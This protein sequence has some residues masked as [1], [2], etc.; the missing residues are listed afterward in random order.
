MSLT[1]YLHPLSSYCHKALIALY[2]NATPFEPHVVDLGSPAARAEF[3]KVW[4]F[5]KFPV[6]RDSTRTQTIPESTSI[7]EY[8]TRHYPGPLRLVPD[9]PD[10]ALQV[11]AADRFY[12]LHVHL[13]M[14]KIVGDLLRP[15]DAHDPIGVKQA[16]E[17]LRTALHIANE[18]LAT[19]PWAAG[20]QFSMADCS[21]APPLFFINIMMPLAGEFPHVGAYHERLKARPSYARVLQ[22]AQPYL[23]YFPGH[24]K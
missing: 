23:C 18:N 7:I 24:P 3:A 6:L 21:A 19:R 8:L 20:D 11:R 2:E 5:A 12:D 14:Q 22:E 16:R 10:K 17:Q 9:D 4:P 1:L 15:A 13:P